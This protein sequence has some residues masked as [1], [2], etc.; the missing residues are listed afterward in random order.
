MLI[1]KTLKGDIMFTYKNNYLTDELSNGR[2]IKIMLM[3][4]NSYWYFLLKLDK[5]FENCFVEVFADGTIFLKNRR[6]NILNDCDLILFFS[7]KEYSSYEF[8]TMKKIAQRISEEKE[9]RVTIGYSYILPIEQ[10][11]E[12][13]YSSEIKISSYKN[14]TESEEIVN[15]ICITD[16]ETLAGITLEKHDDF[17]KTQ[18]FKKIKNSN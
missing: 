9:R 3:S 15:N 16:P 10:R 12:I 6:Y 8:E 14:D 13:K 1:Y 17:E 4:H 11:K 18:T 5:E 2:K 7:S